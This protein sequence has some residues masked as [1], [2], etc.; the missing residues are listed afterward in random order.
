MHVYVVFAHPARRSFTGDVLDE[1][2]RGLDDGGH[3]YEIGDLYEMDFKCEMHLDE[4]TR[5]MNVQGNRSAL[6][7]PSD[8]EVEHCKIGRADGLAF[9]FPVWWSDCP[10]KLKGW[11]DRVWVCGYAY[12]YQF[13]RETYPFPRLAVERALVLCPVGNTLEG[14]EETGIAEAMRRLYTHDRLR[15]DAGVKHCEFALLPGM[16]DHFATSSNRARNLETAY[17]LGRNFLVK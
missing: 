8:V 4:Y 12:E 1:L 2:C 15:P 5:E 13:A 14:L 11:F 17:Q 7:I 3:S 9:V 16:A 6:P 10:A